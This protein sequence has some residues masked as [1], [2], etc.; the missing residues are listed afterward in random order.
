MNLSNMRKTFNGR[1]I[2]IDCFWA[3]EPLQAFAIFPFSVS[4][5]LLF[6]VDE[7]CE[8]T[9]LSILELANVE[10]A[11]SISK[12]SFSFFL[13]ILEL[14]PVLSAISPLHLTFTINL[15]IMELACVSLLT[16]L[17]VISSNTFKQTINKIA[18]IV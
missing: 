5:G 11:I 2:G 15:A 13:S 9:H 1:T 10:V 14:A 16:I 6:N 17:E 8:A 12:G 7:N 18:F 4:L 3:T